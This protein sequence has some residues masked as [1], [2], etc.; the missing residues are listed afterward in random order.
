MFAEYTEFDITIQDGII[1]H[2]RHGGKGPPLLLLHGSVE[3]MDM[4]SCLTCTQISPEPSHLA[5]SRW[6]AR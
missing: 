6:P 4:S 1:I 3:A 2:G 5:S